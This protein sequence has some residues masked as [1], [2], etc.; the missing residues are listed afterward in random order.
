MRQRVALTAVV[1]TVLGLASAWAGFLPF[2]S[3]SAVAATMTGWLVGG[4][5]I[6]AWLDAPRS[7]L[8]PL[9]IVASGAWFVG[10]LRWIDPAISPFADLGRF[11]FV[12]VVGHVTVSIPDG[13]LRTRRGRT[14]VVVGYLAAAVGALI[15]AWVTAAV[16]SV[17]AVAG[18]RLR[19]HDRPDRLVALTAF[20]LALV[21]GAGP[22][23]RSAIPGAAA[24]D[25]TPFVEIAFVALAFAA[26]RAASRAE[27]RARRVADMV[28]ELAARPS[29]GLRDE[30]ALAVDDPTLA[31]AYPLAESGTY[32]DVTG[33]PVMLPS[34]YDDRAVTPLSTGA[35]ELALIIHRPATATDPS[36]L[37]AVAQAADLSSTNAR[38]QAALREAL[39][40]LTAARNRLMDVE[41]AERHRLRDTLERQLEPRLQRIDAALIA[42]REAR[43]VTSVRDIHVDLNLARRDILSIVDGLGPAMLDPHEATV[44]LRELASRSAVPVDLRIHGPIPTGFVGETIYFVVSEGLANVAKHADAGRVTLLI[45]ASERGVRLEVVDDGRGG[46][47]WD[48][49]SGLRGLRE[50]VQASGGQVDIASPVGGGTRISVRIPPSSSVAT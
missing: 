2:Q 32:V 41:E 27:R 29:E 31:I 4:F 16:L 8:G 23:I 33:K 6:V 11:L 3:R 7:R 20:G 21:L 40:Q 44:A 1:L 30:L 34:G 37:S 47:D 48:R 46:A 42:E 38:L 43:P 35:R 45:E 18:A 24:V 5:G 17:Q 36:F 39:F 13:R 19:S 9:L 22:R 10:P 14:L 26:S 12:A 50:R 25:L 28:I 49:G 15:G